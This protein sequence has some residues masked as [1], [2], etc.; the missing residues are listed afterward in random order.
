MS[1]YGPPPP[2]KKELLSA[3][4]SFLF[5]Q[6]A[7]GVHQSELAELWG[8]PQAWHINMTQSWISSAPSE[9]YLITFQC[10]L[11]C[12]LMIYNAPH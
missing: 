6:A 10:V 8:F 5:I 7:V 3:K 1:S 11:S 12:G 4:S 2:T 9:L